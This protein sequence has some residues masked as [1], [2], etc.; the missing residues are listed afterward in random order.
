MT[1]ASYSCVARR[2]QRV[3][4]AFT[5]AAATAH[6]TTPGWPRSTHQQPS[7]LCEGLQ[8]MPTRSTRRDGVGPLPPLVR[9]PSCRWVAV[10]VQVAMTSSASARKG[11][12]SRGRSPSVV[13][14]NRPRSLGRADFYGRRS[15]LVRPSRTSRLPHHASHSASSK[16]WTE[17]QRNASALIRCVGA[18][19]RNHGVCLSV[20]PEGERSEK[21]LSLSRPW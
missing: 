18:F 4:A 7:A 17:T 13:R 5:N 21:A 19:I 9:C 2:G 15:A 11:V 6:V 14:S 1:V 16:H 20:R 3:V 12:S 8:A 10:L